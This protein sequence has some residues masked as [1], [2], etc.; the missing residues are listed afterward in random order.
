MRA[1]DLVELVEKRGL[2]GLQMSWA[3]AVGRPKPWTS[4]PAGWSASASGSQR[5]VGA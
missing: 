3:S 4:R 5:S 2:V 1:E